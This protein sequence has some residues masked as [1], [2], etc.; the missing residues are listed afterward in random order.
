MAVSS[1]WLCKTTQTAPAG[2]PTCTNTSGDFTGTITAASVVAIGGGNV[3]QQIG[4]GEFS[5]VL[6]AIR[7]GNAYVNV[8]TNL[9]TGGEIRG[10]IKVNGNDDDDED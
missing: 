5:K 8:H 9:S 3:G 7:A 1:I 6:A 10:Q 4:A 2:T